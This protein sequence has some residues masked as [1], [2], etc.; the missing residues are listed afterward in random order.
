[1][2][3]LSIYIPKADIKGEGLKKMNVGLRAC[4]TWIIKSRKNPFTA[5][6]KDRTPM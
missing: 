2:S 4:M 5:G 1:M 6:Y 3:I